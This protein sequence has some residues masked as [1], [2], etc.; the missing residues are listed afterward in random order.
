MTPPHRLLGVNDFVEELSRFLL[1]S[2]LK[3]RY[4][5][6]EEFHG[7]LSGLVETFL[8]ESLGATQT[9]YALWR[10]V[11]EPGGQGIIPTRAFG[12]SYTPDM[13]VDIAGRPTLAILGLFLPERREAGD[14]LAEALGKALILSMAYPAVFV[15]C[16][17]PD[18]AV[19]PSGLLDR[20][21]LMDLW[22]R[23][24]VRVTMR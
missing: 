4:G 9:P 6:Q 14:R 13:V 17:A 12:Q 5:D 16:Y 20:E 23:H 3:D 10:G 2:S 7:H 22:S 8:R 18:A 15:F 21:I 1:R 19:H 24:K 11:A